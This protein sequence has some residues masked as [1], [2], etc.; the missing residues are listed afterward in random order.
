M[1]GENICK[2]EACSIQNCLN[3]NNYDETKCSKAIDNLYLCCKEFYKTTGTSAT[4]TCCPIFEKLQIKLKQRKL[5][6]IDTKP[7]TDH[8]G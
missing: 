1:T 2:S 5:G 4:T 6:E 3:A 7:L 8:S